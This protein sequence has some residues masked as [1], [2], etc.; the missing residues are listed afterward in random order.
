MAAVLGTYAGM[1]L[2]NLIFEIFGYECCMSLFEDNY[3]CLKWLN[4]SSKKQ[5]RSRHI[6]VAYCFVKELVDSKQLLLNQVRSEDQL[7][8]LLTKPVTS[9]TFKK[10]MKRLPISS[11]GVLQDEDEMESTGSCGYV[12]VAE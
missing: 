7:A 8:D 4:P 3:A 12:A 9:I 10:M 5:G 1:F 11:G 2:R 6:K